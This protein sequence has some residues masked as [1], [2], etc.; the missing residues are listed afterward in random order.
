MQDNTTL[1]PQ[2]KQN[3]IGSE[4]QKAEQASAG[5]PISV[6]MLSIKSANLTLTEA[7]MTANRSSSMVS[8]GLSM[9]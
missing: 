7:S 8:S 4:L 5:V 9:R 1:N 3:L 2:Q 6:G